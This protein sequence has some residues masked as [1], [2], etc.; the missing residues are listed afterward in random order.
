MCCCRLLSSS[1]R[2]RRTHR[3]KFAASKAKGLWIGGAPPLGYGIHERALIVNPAEADLARRWAD[4]LANGKFASVRAIAHDHRLCH[5]YV[6]KL[7]PLTFLAPDLAQAVLDGRQ[8]R[9]LSISNLLAEPL[10]LSW[11][12]QRLR[13]RGG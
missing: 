8:P 3:D 13:F 7:L 4:D 2:S 5:L 12:Q 1:A 9:G 10:P 6:G 11:P